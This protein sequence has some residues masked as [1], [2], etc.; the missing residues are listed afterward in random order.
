MAVS[1][2]RWAVAEATPGTRVSVR[3]TRPTQ[4]AQVMPPTV[5]RS[6]GAD[7]S[8]LLAAGALIGT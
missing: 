8:G 2:A 4:F 7:A 3:S 1:G 6:A 5:K